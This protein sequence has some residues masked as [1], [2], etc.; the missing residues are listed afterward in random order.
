MRSRLALAL[1]PLALVAAACG[2]GGGG[3]GDGSQVGDKLPTQDTTIKVWSFLPL[4]YDGGKA[5]YKHV[6]DGF[7]KKHPNI[8]VDLKNIPYDAYWDQLRNSSVAGTGPDVVT[9]YG[10]TTAAGYVG[11]FEP[12]QDALSKKQRSNLKFL[13]SSVGPDGNLYALPTGEY[14]Y[15][16]TVN[17]TLLNKAGLDPGTALSSWDGLLSTCKTLKSAG[18]TPFA[19]GWSDGYQLE[20]LMYMMMSQLLDPQG[21]K[22]WRAAKIGFDDKRFATALGY[23][24]D[25]KQAGCFGEDSLG[26][27]M[28]NDSF[29]QI[30]SGKAA[31]FTSGSSDS[32]LKGNKQLGQGTMTIMPF[33]QLPQSQYSRVIDAGP[34]AGWAVTSWSGHKAA[35]W[36]LVSY[37][38]EADTQRYVYK[39]TG[40]PP[41]LSDVSVTSDDPVVS[42][43]LKLLSLPDNH[44]TYMAFTQPAL[45]SLERDASGFI[46]GRKSAEDVLKSADEAQD[47]ALANLK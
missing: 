13:D 27:S 11:A 18:I 28:Y 24:Q 26:K 34:E 10:G 4:N 2:G 37:L 9:V 1:V 43:Y 47:K 17:K 7:R 5:T 46:A 36:A 23:I 29:T 45:A 30:A 31:I 12:L 41:N 38:A 25:M 3:G 40:T 22:D 19:A 21:L 42:E 15:T 39:K 44:T 8:T 14:G 6:M 33:P 35:A 16:L 32:A 20:T